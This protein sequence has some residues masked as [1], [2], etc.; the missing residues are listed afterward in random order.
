MIRITGKGHTECPYCKTIFS[1][2]WD[3]LGAKI[4]YCDCTSGVGEN[5]EQAK[6]DWVNKYN[7]KVD[8]FNSKEQ[9]GD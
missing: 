5:F 4:V 6:Q 2:T 3:S 7:A 1:G 8:K 9:D